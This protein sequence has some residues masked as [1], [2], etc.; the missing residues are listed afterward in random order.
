MPHNGKVVQL[1]LNEKEEVIASLL[2][3]SRGT[4][5]PCVVVDILTNQTGCKKIKLF[6]VCQL[7][8]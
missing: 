8:N 3:W 1:K 2:D 4:E 6:K 5:C 7:L